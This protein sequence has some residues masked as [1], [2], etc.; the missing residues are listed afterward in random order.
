MTRSSLD[1]IV[2]TAGDPTVYDQVVELFDELEKLE[3][4]DAPKDGNLNPKTGA[5]VWDP[6]YRL[7]RKLSA[8]GPDAQTLRQAELRDQI[9]SSLCET[10]KE[11]E[12]TERGCPDE[13]ID[14]TLMAFLS[15]FST[16]SFLGPLLR[17]HGVLFAGLTSQLTR[18]P[19]SFFEFLR[20]YNAFL[21][22]SQVEQLWDHFKLMLDS[23]DPSWDSAERLRTGNYGVWDG[24]GGGSGGGLYK[25][26]T[27]AADH[28]FLLISMR[29]FFQVAYASERVLLEVATLTPRDNPEAI[30]LNWNAMRGFEESFKASA[31]AFFVSIF[32]SDYFNFM[33]EDE[34]VDPDVVSVI[35]PTWVGDVTSL[36]DAARSLSAEE[37]VAPC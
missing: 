23:L 29:K 34:G 12:R 37:A 15:S 21:S 1:F 3:R 6:A 14:A 31:P 20:A 7:K 13:L 4:L 5:F 35:L 10:F 24:L 17:R 27:P 2:G 9:F 22:T 36:L 25:T 33:V 30:S 28:S 18:T 19:S 11:V 26:L 16:T 8:L 32:W